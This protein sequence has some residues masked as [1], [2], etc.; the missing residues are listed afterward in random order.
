MANRIRRVRYFYTMVP[1]R[2]GRGAKVLDALAKSR[3]NLLA[4]SGF[5][6]GRGQ[7]QLDFVPDDGAAFQRAMKRAGVKLSAARVGFLLQGVDK[8]GV[9]ARIL[10]KL[11]KAKINVVAM[12][13]V[14]AGG[15]RYG[16]ILW[17]RPKDVGRATRALG[18][19]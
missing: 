11:G 17:V 16:A 18:A 6:A 14:T 4:Y 10:G 7:A 13:A 19:R 8:V 12:D 3:V 2:P 5:P 9:C 1:D 15:R